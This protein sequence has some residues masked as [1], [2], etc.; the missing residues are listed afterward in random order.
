MEKAKEYAISLGLDGRVF[1]D[2]SL[3][4]DMSYYNGVIF[5]GF[6]SGIPSAVLSGGRYDPLLHRFGRNI[7]AC[8]FAIYLDRLTSFEKQSDMDF[9][10]L[11]LYTEETSPI[12]VAAK[13]SAIVS[14]GKRVL[15]AKSRPDGVKFGKIIDIK[16]ANE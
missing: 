15:A 8:G 3:I 13:V 6:V 7:G 11:L 10:V 12:T 2:F 4:N 9:D 5:R 16:E 1:L 14:A